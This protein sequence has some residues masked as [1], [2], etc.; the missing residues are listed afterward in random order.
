MENKV[1]ENLINAMKEAMA[2][3]KDIEVCICRKKQEKL[4]AKKNNI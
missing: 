4:W 2:N 3:K 1:H